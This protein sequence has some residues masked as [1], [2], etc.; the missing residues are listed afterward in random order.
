MQ[1]WPG[2]HHQ[3]FNHLTWG[4]SKK[5]MW[6]VSHTCRWYPKTCKSG[7]QDLSFSH[8]SRAFRELLGQHCRPL[9]Q[10]HQWR[11]HFSYL[12]LF[13]GGK[14]LETAARILISCRICCLM[15]QRWLDRGREKPG[16]KRSRAGGGLASIFPLRPAVTQ[17][18]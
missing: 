1:P 4:V 9:R 13:P 11:A 3:L 15:K 16:F 18:T 17:T 5:S 14:P 7:I 8:V 10:Q 2:R 12:S 6:R